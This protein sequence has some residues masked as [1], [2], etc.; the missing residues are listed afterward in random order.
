MPYKHII[1]WVVLEDTE[2]ILYI[3]GIDYFKQFTLVF[4]T[5]NLKERAMNLLI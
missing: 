5:E 1:T 4:V 2:K 3:P